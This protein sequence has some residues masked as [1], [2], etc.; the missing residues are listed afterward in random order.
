MSAIPLPRALMRATQAL[1][2]NR[3]LQRGLPRF[4]RIPVWRLSL[5]LSDGFWFDTTKFRA[6]YRKPL[7]NVE[8]G[9]RDTL[10]EP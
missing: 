7:R 9:L 3:A 4:A 6:T 2:W 8:Q 10:R 5:I 1:I